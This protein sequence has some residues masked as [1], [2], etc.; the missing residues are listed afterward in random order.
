MEISSSLTL[1]LPSSLPPLPS[2]PFSASGSAF[3]VNSSSLSLSNK[4]KTAA[5]CKARKGSLVIGISRSGATKERRG[6]TCNAL[7]G[8]GVPELVVI[9]GVAALVFGPKKLPE[10]GK[11]IG[12]TVKSFQQAAKEFE[13][14]LK[15]DPDY[16]SEIPTT[17]P[18]AVSEEK[19]E[20]PISI[21]MA[22]SGHEGLG[23]EFFEHI[24][25]PP[26]GGYAGSTDYRGG[27]GEGPGDI[28]RMHMVLQLG[29]SGGGSGERGGGGMGMLPL[30]LNLEQSSGGLLAARDDGGGGVRRL[31]DELANN[32]HSPSSN[33]LVNMR[34]ELMHNMTGLFPAFGQLQ[35]PP[36]P[37][38]PQPP[39]RTLH[40]P[41]QT[42]HAGGSISPAPNPPAV[43][44][45][46]RARRGQATDPHS[47]AERLRRERIAER[48]KALQELVP[49]CNKTD[50]AAMLDEIVDYVKFLRLQVKVLLLDSP[51]HLLWENSATWN[52]K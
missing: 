1:S 19:K 20:D 52:F 34:G 4:V 31:M 40:Q 27:G 47:I 45:R 46:V 18:K 15:K 14:E 36:Q 41:F 39:V 28:G 44:P 10:V 51:N 6:L 30:G 35:P 22:G 8:L 25:A 42:Q 5:Y 9:A 26:P 2:L 3:F 37:L 17:T 23:D 48:M 13:S 7:F 29:S 21:R 38:R 11:S 24:M 32:H 43:R 33:S 50:R 12:K 49:S 16:T